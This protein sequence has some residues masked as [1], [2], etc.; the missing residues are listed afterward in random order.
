M[1]YL[2][3][4]S[5]NESNAFRTTNILWDI[6]EQTKNEQKNEKKEERK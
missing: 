2:Y 4:H 5:D 1:E 3:G 6:S